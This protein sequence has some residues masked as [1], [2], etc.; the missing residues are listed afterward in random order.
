MYAGAQAEYLRA[1]EASGSSDTQRRFALLLAHIGACH[2]LLD[3]GCGW[4]QF[5]KLAQARVPE[6][7]GVDE[8]PH[9][10]RDIQQYCP[11]AHVVV[12]R[13]DR[14]ELPSGYFD[15]VVTSQ[16][17]HEVKLTGGAP[18]LAVVVGEIW[19]VLASGGRYL[20]LDHQDAGEGDVVARLPEGVLPRLRAFE[21]RY[22]YYSASHEDL[23]D[24]LV[25]MRRRCLQDWLT[26]EW[27]LDSPMESLEMNETHNAFS[28]DEVRRFL[29][30]GGFSVE[31]W[32]PFAEVHQDLA[33]VGGEFVAGVPWQRKFL[34]VSTKPGHSHP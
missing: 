34:A 19:R 1:R 8:S 26:K 12:C 14:L 18:A 9:R 2:H 7:W 33:R 31:E 30:Q 6:I 24:G 10:V 11:E 5:L 27:A 29:E 25:R 13:A 17:L 4:G 22:R 21:A 32:V 23:G 28:E 15:C 3:I 20:L 16:M